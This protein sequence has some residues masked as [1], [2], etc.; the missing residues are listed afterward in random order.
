M[1]RA[2]LTTEYEGGRHDVRL[3]KVAR[4]ERKDT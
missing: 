4:L 2:F 3:A 1:V